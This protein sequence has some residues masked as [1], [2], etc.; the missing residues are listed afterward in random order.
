MGGST[1]L[2]LTDDE[3]QDLIQRPKQLPSNFRSKLKLK[4]VANVGHK[5]ANLDLPQDDGS[6]F[7]LALRQRT[8]NPFDFSVI[9]SYSPPNTN[10]TINLRRYNG[11][12]HEHTNN[13]EKMKFETAFH[14][15]IATERYQKAKLKAE[16]YAEQTDR[17]N[18]IHGA[19]QCMLDDCGF[20][21]PP[22]PRGMRLDFKKG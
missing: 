9:L 21:E 7:R 4:D 1:T 11:K 17:Y 19:L 14:I 12:S 15:H 20:K 16:K 6:V 18:D 8:S 3:I 10:A 5:K 22:D 13:L 2:F